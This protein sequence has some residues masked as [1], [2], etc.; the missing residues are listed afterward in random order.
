MKKIIIIVTVVVALIVCGIFLIR[1]DQDNTDVTK[2]TTKVGFIFNGEIDDKSWGQS[3]YE[4]IMKCKDSLNLDIIYR[5]CVPETEDSIS[6]M[7]EL[8]EENCKIIIVN[9]FGYG[10]YELEVASRHPEVK[11]FHATGVKEADNLSTYFGRIYQMRYLSGMVAGMQT[12]SDEIGY[13]A[14]FP[15]SEVNRGLNAFTEGVRKV[16][17]NAKVYVIFSNTWTDDEITRKAGE[18]LLEDY[19]GI[20]VISMHTDSLQILELADE[21][22]IWSIGYNIDNSELYPDSFLTAPVW[23][24][25]KFYEPRILECLQG[26]FQSKHYW[27]GAETGVVDLAPL[28][29]NVKPGIE[30]V[31]NAEKEKLN[32]GS[33]DVFYGEIIDNEGNVR[34]PLGESMSDDAMLNEFDWYVEGVVID[35]K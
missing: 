4:G 29:K 32:N 22:G 14:A 34:V 13:V 11:F 10:E 30:E 5:E 8:V 24:W 23:D 12:E 33:F 20:D 7:E 1:Q 6:I 18:K 35:E 26:K 17:P 19:P 27:E 2:K 28:S 3:H 15:I 16:N 21:K 25:S 31:I 9:S